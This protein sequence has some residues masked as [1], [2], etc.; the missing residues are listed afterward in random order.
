LG[1]QQK[2]DNESH[3][4]NIKINI[5]FIEL[6][7]N[8]T[9]AHRPLDHPPTYMNEDV[10]SNM[11]AFVLSSARTFTGVNGPPETCPYDEGNRV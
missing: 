5:T 2:V 11:G 10:Y 8:R 6:E 1:V 3:P 4:Q 7:P 9:A